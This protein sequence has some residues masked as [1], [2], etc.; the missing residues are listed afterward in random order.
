MERAERAA[1]MPHQLIL[2]QRN[3]LELTGVSDLDSFDE[4]T[5]TAYTS[6]GELTVRGRQLHVLA[7]DL[8]NGSLSLEGQ[9]DS[10]TYVDTDGRTGFFGRLFR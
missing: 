5:V 6:L 8:E 4:A 9:V 3:R 10:L 1:G 7:L 2:Q